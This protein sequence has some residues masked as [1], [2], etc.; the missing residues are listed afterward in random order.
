MGFVTAGLSAAMVLAFISWIAWRHA[1]KRWFLPFPHWLGWLIDLDNPFAREHRARAIVGR[2]GCIEGMSVLDIGCGSGRL[3]RLLAEAVGPAG[4]VM[5]LDAQPEMLE[6]VLAKAH[7][8]MLD[9]VVTIQATV[10]TGSLVV[11]PVDRAVLVAVLGEIPDR[12]A[13][14]RDVFAAL[15]PEGILSVTE[16]VFDPHY[17]RR[18]AVEELAAKA[19]FR[20]HAAFGSRVAYTLHLQRPPCGEKVPETEVAGVG[21]PL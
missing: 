9:N 7:G 21:E 3:T 2:L 4:K 11:V 13:A 18:E 10:G 1:S 5:A 20:V 15:R 6:R 12:E 14:M 19:G 8:E 16:T 17:Q